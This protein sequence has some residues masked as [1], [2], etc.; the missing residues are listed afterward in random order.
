[1][2]A[3]IQALITEGVEGAEAEREAMG[4]NMGS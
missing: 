1:M 2:Q 4:S 3:Q